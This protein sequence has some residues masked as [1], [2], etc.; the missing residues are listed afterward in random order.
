MPTR[1]QVLE[2]LDAGHGYETV[3]RVLRI[4]PGQAFMIATGLPAD[5]S[6]SP[7]RDELRDNPVLPGSSQHLVN[8]A[9]VNPT[10]DETVIAWVKARAARELR[11]ES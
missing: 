8:P 5:G 10:R 6:D 1:A 4:P 2:L 3:G 11:Q 7:H 9:P